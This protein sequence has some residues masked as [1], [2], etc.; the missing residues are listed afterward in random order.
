MTDS[1]RALTACMSSFVH[2]LRKRIKDRAT[3]RLISS[4]VD[5]TASF[6]IRC[7]NSVAA[8]RTVCASHSACGA[9]I[10]QWSQL[11]TPYLVHCTTL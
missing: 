1:P 10:L 6:S 7:S 9:G 8:V 4:S 5:G 3:S 11:K 2:H